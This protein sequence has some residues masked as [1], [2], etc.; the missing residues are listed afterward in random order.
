MP[1]PNN[2][3]TQTVGDKGL[4]ETVLIDGRKV[5]RRVKAPKVVVPPKEDEPMVAANTMYKASNTNYGAEKPNKAHE[6]NRVYPLDGKFTRGFNGF[7]FQKS[8]MYHGTP[9]DNGNTCHAD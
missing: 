3:F 8:D 9:G 1:D 6:I 5:V 2:P 4:L 7:K